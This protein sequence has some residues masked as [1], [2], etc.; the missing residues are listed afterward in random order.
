MKSYFDTL[1]DVVAYV[2]NESEDIVSELLMMGFTPAQ[3]VHDFSFDEKEVKVSEVYKELDEELQ[4]ELE[5]KEYPF[6]LSGFNTFDAAL[7]SR[8]ELNK[9]DFL[10]FKETELY[11]EIFANYEDEIIEPETEVLNEVFDTFENKIFNE[12]QKKGVGQELFSLDKKIKNA[13][14]KV[15]ERSDANRPE[16]EEMEI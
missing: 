11:N 5:E 14:E 6:V 7:I 9:E 2:R 4:N 10:C 3:L 8:F 16:R 1:K 12:F 13:Q 15:A